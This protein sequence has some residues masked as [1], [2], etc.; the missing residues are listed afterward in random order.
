MKLS[1]VS[2]FCLIALVF[3]A[4]ACDDLNRFSYENYF[5]QPRQTALYEISVGKLKQG[6]SANIQF[7]SKLVQAEITMLT[8]DEIIMESEGMRII[9]NRQTGSTKIF[10]GNTFEKVNCVVDKFKM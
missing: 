3:V 6:A 4:T 1:G 5:C 10:I 8:Q 7:A 9:A 2:L